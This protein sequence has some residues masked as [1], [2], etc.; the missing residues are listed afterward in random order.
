MKHLAVHVLVGA[1]LV[2][3]V[4]VPTPANA[5]IQSCGDIQIIFRNPDL[6]PKSDG[7]IYAQGQFFAQFQAIGA[8]ADKIAV[9]GFSFG[10]QTVDV[11]G[12]VCDAP[13]WATGAYVLNYRADRDA[14]DGF[15][16][17]LKTS[18]VPDGTYAAAVHAYDA[19]NNELARFWA[20]AQVKN[21]DDSTQPPRCDGDI[22]QNTRHD[23]TAPWPMV[24]PG[25]GQP[26]E[27]HSLTI[28]FGE[29]LSW[30]AVTIN[31]K[32]VTSELTEWEGRVW[33]ADLVPDYGPA[34][35]GNTVS[36]PCTHPEPVNQCIKYGPAFEW[37]T[38]PLT[39]NDVIRV[40]AADLAGNIALK[41]I[42]IG[43]SVAG[44]AVTEEVPIL[45]YTVDKEKATINAGG[46][47][48]FQFEIRNNGGGTGHPF[49][50]ATGP[51]GWTLNWEPVHVVV[52]PGA[53]KS[54]KLI[55]TAPGNA[56]KG[57]HT[58]HAVLKY[59]AGSEEKSLEQPLDIIIGTAS[60]GPAGNETTTTTTK[61][62]KSP[63]AGVV[64]GASLLMVA[65][66]LRRRD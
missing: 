47:A 59:Q 49:A 19:N 43:S 7:F 26:L 11:P 15:F 9:L 28:E 2:G 20:K 16:I 61:A 1:I 34:G 29:P 5:Q 41:T 50:E 17:P 37:K 23:K 44:G 27:G 42:H 10:P 38:R 51:E 63:G 58:V 22:E 33:D 30:Y 40:E 32:N 4:I 54:Q 6:Q 65:I 31:G 48:T 14:S 39:N 45:S 62:K 13:L 12:S 55:V 18:L 52:E 35:A 56:P 3:L 21:C 66:A 8:D 25:D 36:P 57:T 46:S 60:A 64:L 53:T 24:L